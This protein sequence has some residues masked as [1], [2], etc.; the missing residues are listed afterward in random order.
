MYM[1][2]FALLVSSGPFHGALEETTD[3]SE[4]RLGPDRLWRGGGG[5]LKPPFKISL[6][7]FVLCQNMTRF[8]KQK[9]R[10]LI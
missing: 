7:V 1:S 3:A 5:E 6:P 2:V 4:L 8:Q 10:A 9:V